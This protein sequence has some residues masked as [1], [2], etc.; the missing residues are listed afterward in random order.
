LLGATLGFAPFNKPAA[1][2][3]L[4]DV[5]SLPIGLLVGWLLL[6][7]AAK[8]YVAAAILLPLYYLADATI[9]LGRRLVAGEP[10]WRAHRTHF[11]QRATD[12]GFSVPEIIARVAAVNLAL[13]VLA[14]TTVVVPGLAAT[15]LA[16]VAGAAIVGWLLITFA[17]SKG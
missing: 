5:G 6:H 14:M 3:F 15:S 13:V 8:G 2:L 17:R 16:L 11:Y 9:T 12:N 10:V 4:G 7:V 1:R